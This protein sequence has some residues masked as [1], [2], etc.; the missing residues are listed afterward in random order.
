MRTSATARRRDPAREP[1]VGHRR[2]GLGRGHHR[3]RR[4]ALDERPR[5][6]HGALA[7][8]PD[9]ARVDRLVGA[10]V[11][12]ALG[13]GEV[14]RHHVGAGG[15]RRRQLLA[16]DVDDRHRAR[17][18]RQA[19]QP[20]VGVG[21][22]ARR[23]RPAARQHALAAQRV[24]HHALVELPLAGR[25]RRP[26]LVEHRHA[27]RAL[28]HDGGRTQLAADLDAAHDDSLVAQQRRAGDARAPR[29]QADEH[30]VGAE[31]ARHPRH[32]DALAARR[33][34]G[35]LEAQHL[36][37]AQLVDRQGAIDGEV[38]AGDDH[39][40]VILP[41]DAGARRTARGVPM[42]EPCPPPTA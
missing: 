4:P 30:G 33:H 8:D 34:R 32:V 12:Q 36:A 27:P 3:A 42:I 16:A 28:E 38:G 40:R 9:V 35:A 21:G 7:H 17:G 6:R 23:Q 14:R 25:Q 20:R 10:P 13:L 18:V 1:P 5:R 29:Q 2:A 26:G 41:R 37:R 15:D 22:G 19:D 39:G 31:V 11:Q 24:G